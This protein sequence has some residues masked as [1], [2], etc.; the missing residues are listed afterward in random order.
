LNGLARQT[1]SDEAASSVCVKS[2]H[3]EKGQMV[4]VPEC[5]KALL[6]NLLV[7]RR[8]HQEHY[9]EGQREYVRAKIKAR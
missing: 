6:P 3:E 7:R 2:D 1:T 4:G 9:F 8:V 5:F